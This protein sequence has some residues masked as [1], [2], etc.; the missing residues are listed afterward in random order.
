MPQQQYNDPAGGNP[1]SIGSQF[2]TFKYDKMALIEARKKH[3]FGDIS[4]VTN[5]P[6]HFGKKIKKNHYIPL[7]D[8]QNI[9]DQGI[10]AAGVTIDSTKWSAWD[11]SRNL[12]GNSYNDEASAKAAPGSIIVQQNSGNLYGSSKDVG[13]VSAKMPLLS[14]NGGKVNRVGYQR[15]ELEGSMEKLGLYDNYTKES[16]DFDTDEQLE[17]HLRR[18]MVNAAVELTEDLLQIDLLSAAGVLRYP[19][20][21]TQDSEIDDTAVTYGDLL[22]LSI[23]LDNNRTPKQT[24]VITGT[25]FIDT[26]T[27]PGGRL[28]YIGSELIPTIEAMTDTFGKQAYISSEKYASAG[29]V[30][31]GEIGTVGHFKIIVVPE[32]MKWS[33][34]GADASGTSTHYETAD[35]YDLFPML[36]VGDSSFTTIGFQTDGKSVK[37]KIKHAKPE[38]VES[39]AMD[40]YGETGFNSIKFYYGFLL[41][42][43]ER[44]GLIK[45]AAIL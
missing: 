23:D 13:L 10:D 17:M 20:A 21:A 24:K 26:R 33:G 9:N 32:M 1:S 35:K 36:T 44:I 5:M 40:P 2:N 3:F 8:E 41:E 34:A 18:E 25:R 14:E 38:S 27:V 42:R 29:S 12:I 43:P 6:K 4:S 45:T 19:G 22:R 15:K 31:T 28:M 30:V 39:Y 7:L 16:M 37:F 11:A